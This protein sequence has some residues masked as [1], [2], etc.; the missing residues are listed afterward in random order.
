MR[1]R[2]SENLFGTS[3]LPKRAELLPKFCNLGVNFGAPNGVLPKGCR[4]VVRRRCV[5]FASQADFPN[6]S[7]KVLPFANVSALSGKREG[8]RSPVKVV[9]IHRK[10]P[11]TL[12]FNSTIVIVD[13]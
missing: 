4:L 10:H 12:F 2:P 3:D 7:Q 1:P 8:S 11:N 9:C 6:G 13:G 5:D